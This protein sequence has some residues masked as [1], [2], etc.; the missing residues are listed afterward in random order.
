MVFDSGLCFLSLGMAVWLSRR[1]GAAARR[2]RTVL[3]VVPILLSAAVLVELLSGKS[4]AV[5]FEFLHSWYDYGNTRPGRMAPNS[6]I[7][8]I[9]VGFG[10]LL[11]DRVTSRSRGIGV[12]LVTFCVL[13]VGL[14]GL[15]GYALTPDLLFEWTR[16]ARMAVPTAAGMILCSVGL[17][18]MWSESRW[19]IS[20]RY[21][22]E[23]EKIRLL[24]PATLAVVT[25]TAALS[26]FVL[27][28]NALQ[29][30]LSSRLQSVLH[31]RSALFAVAT[32][33][34][35]RLALAADRLARL[36]DPGVR[37]LLESNPTTEAASAIDA[38]MISASL[39]GIALENGAGVMVRSF[40]NIG[41][42]TS[43]TVP[44]GEG[45]E[46]LWDGEMIVRTRAPLWRNEKRIGTVVVEQSAGSLEKALFDT[47]N[48]GRTGEIAVC[49]QGGSDL[50]CFP[51]SRHSVPF[52]VVPSS[53]GGPRLPMQLALAGQ[54]GDVVSVDYRGQNVI[55]AYGLLAPGLGIVVKQDAV[56]LYA[57]IRQSLQIGLPLFAAVALVGA[58]MLYL[59]LK[60][61][62]A[63]LLASEAR[64][65]ERELQMRAVIETVAEGIFTFDA[66]CL[67]EDVNPAICEI[68]GYPAG[69]LIGN[70]TS[71]LMPDKTRDATYG[72]LHEDQARGLAV[73]AGQLNVKL[74]GQRKDGSE[75]P[76]ELTIR[77][78]SF[79][80]RRSFVGIARDITERM[81]A[82]RKL[83]ALGRYDSL[84]A[85]PNRSLFLERL[86][87]TAAHMDRSGGAIAL[88][89]IDVGWL[90]GDQ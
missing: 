48:L 64:A 65:C 24:G 86:K 42:T 51:G 35:I 82:E 31:D 36:A 83:T 41:A 6:A 2:T 4:L 13:A 88:M 15:V 23:D 80:G 68:F 7:G 16:S 27:Q 45:S 53:N 62:A 26:G 5:D 22:R 25:A 9:L 85:L 14:T 18:L 34:R 17:R 43:M 89:F 72:R 38:E 63:Q 55:A 32:T 33:R 81:E 40:G 59:Q 11:A 76:L 78:S 66:N 28:Q 50:L 37:I 87:A 79:S 10:I 73:L 3:A 54:T 20:H 74:S 1:P 90:Q 67:I 19:Y 21:F 69:E 12:M 29:K 77:E 8:F 75:F 60:P 46:L 49:M 56:E 39:R 30:L 58:G 71:M 47:A 44:L 52:T 70:S 57:L 84:T 61:L